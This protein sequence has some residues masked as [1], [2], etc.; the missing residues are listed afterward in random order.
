MQRGR[1]ALSFQCFSIIKRR[2]WL[3]PG[4]WL[5]G[6]T[7]SASGALSRH[8]V[9]VVTATRPSGSLTS[10]CCPWGR[11]CSQNKPNILR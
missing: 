2:A 7:S 8:S 6:G 4:E 1:A 10:V 5:R 11:R 3:S 9:T